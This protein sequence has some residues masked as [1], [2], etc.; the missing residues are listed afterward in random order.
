[1]I[2]MIKNRLKEDATLYE[3]NIVT[4]AFIHST[5]GFIDGIEASRKQEGQALQEAKKE[6]MEKVEDCPAMCTCDK[7]QDEFMNPKS[8]KKEGT[9][10]AIKAVRAIKKRKKARLSDDVGIV[11]QRLHNNTRDK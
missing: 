10:K 1:M 8:E 4:M 6:D 2:E 11:K 5:L 3:G 7:C 9:K